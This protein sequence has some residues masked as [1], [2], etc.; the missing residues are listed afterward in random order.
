MR[1]AVGPSRGKQPF[2]DSVQTFPCGFSERGIG[3]YGGGQTELGPGRGQAQY[4]ACLFHPDTPNDVAPAGYNAEPLP[5]GLPGSP[6]APAPSATGFG[7]R[8]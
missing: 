6:L 5:P 1:V 3:A 4:L 8:Q 7:W 2:F